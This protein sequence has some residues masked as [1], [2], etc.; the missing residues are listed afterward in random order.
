MNADEAARSA[1]LLVTEAERGTLVVSG[2][3]RIGWL[4][5]IVTS[6]LVGL[7]PEHGVFGLILSKTGKIV[8]DLSFVASADQS[9]I[10]TAAG[11]HSA[12]LRTFD[13]MLVMED[14][15]IE[16][17]SA[18]HTWLMLHGPRAAAAAEHARQRVAGASGSIDWSGLGGAALVV[19][20][21]KIDVA[22]E[23][24]REASPDMVRATADDWTRFR[25]E[26]GVGVHGVDFG[27]EDNPHEAALDQ[28]AI[29]WTKGCYLGQEVVCMQGMRGTVKR[30]LVSL[31]IDGRDAPARGARV[32]RVRDGSDVGEVTSACTSERL[33][34]VVALARVLGAAAEGNEPL[35]VD[36]A[37]ARVVPRPEA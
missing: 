19:E 32:L 35:Q 29:C 30:R 1:V 15:E 8:S 11:T 10:S 33:S 37:S 16:D 12:L 21:T 31:I 26:R 4:D 2:P 13:Q 9:F 3:D 28:R 18:S 14:A 6:S 27:P 20:T 7:R 5:G 23:A 36:G 24:V 17:R 22:L 34:T 25:L